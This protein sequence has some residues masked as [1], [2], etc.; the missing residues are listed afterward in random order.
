M[1]P[2]LD[3]TIDDLATN[4]IV[5]EDQNNDTDVMSSMDDIN[6]NKNL[7]PLCDSPFVEG[8]ESD[9][10]DI[11]VA[12]I[13]SSTDFNIFPNEVTEKDVIIITKQLKD[14]TN[15]LELRPRKSATIKIEVPA[16]NIDI[17]K[18]IVPVISEQPKADI[19]QDIVIPDEYYEGRILWCKLKSYPWWPGMIYHS[20]EKNY[21][22]ENYVHVVYFG[23]NAERG[24]IHVKDVFFMRVRQH[25]T[26]L[27]INL[28]L[29][30][31]PNMY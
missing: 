25:T 18:I 20:P 1:E 29:T 6:S 4:E 9:N 21:Y 2:D 14:V 7:L 27:S 19:A 11:T 3:F 28:R 5:I 8:Y 15:M 26:S 24:W 12:M 10:S 30:R 31:S 22:K 13:D 23:P 17:S 16:E